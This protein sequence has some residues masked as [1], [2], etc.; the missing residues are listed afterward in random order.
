[1]SST[2]YVEFD[3]GQVKGPGL[4]TAEKSAYSELVRSLSSFGRAVVKYLP[5]DNTLLQYVQTA[6]EDAKSTT[7]AELHLQTVC[8]N[9]DKAA[10]TMTTE[11]QHVQFAEKCARI[12][13]AK[14]KRMKQHSRRAEARAAKLGNGADNVSGKA[15]WPSLIAETA[16]NYQ[17]WRTDIVMHLSM[18]VVSE[19]VEDQGMLVNRNDTTRTK[20]QQKHIKKLLHFHSDEVGVAAFELKGFAFVSRATGL[21]VKPSQANQFD[22]M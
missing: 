21:M 11:T 13:V 1:M 5:S 14:T 7:Q 19:Y 12:L 4:M 8:D 22:L 3:V 18:L 9:F 2:R 17:E 15:R 10:N 20:Q 16:N 6:F